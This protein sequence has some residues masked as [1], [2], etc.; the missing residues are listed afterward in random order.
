MK[1]KFL[2]KIRKAVC[3]NCVHHPNTLP[4]LLFDFYDEDE[5]GVL[6]HH[7]AVVNGAYSNDLRYEIFW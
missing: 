7:L 5:S 6:V 2:Q 3:E 4:L 1:V